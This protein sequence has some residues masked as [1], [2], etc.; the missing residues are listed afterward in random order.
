V[1][2]GYLSNLEKGVKQPSAVTLHRIAAELGVSIE[3]ISYPA[4]DDAAA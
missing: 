2:Q 4:S 3:A 1:S